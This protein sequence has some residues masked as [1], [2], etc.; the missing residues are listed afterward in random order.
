M[1]W[2]FIDGYRA[3]EWSL[4]RQAIRL[5]RI[6]AGKSSSG[7]VSVDLPGQP[8]RLMPIER[9]AR[10][11]MGRGGMRRAHRLDIGHD[12]GGEGR[13]LGAAH[14]DVQ[15]KAFHGRRQPAIGMVDLLVGVHPLLVMVEQLERDG[16]LV[17]KVQFPDIAEVDLGGVDG[18][19]ALACVGRAKPHRF[20]RLVAA[21]IEQDIVVGHVHVAVVVDP[22]LLDLKDRGNEGRGWF[23]HGDFRAVFSWRWTSRDAGDTTLP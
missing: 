17:A 3:K 18:E 21:A 23:R 9:P 20:E 2:A 10:S 15:R 1:S 4:Q 12:V 22:V 16:H 7:D 19:L 13:D 11:G 6:E 5:R 14:V 8:L